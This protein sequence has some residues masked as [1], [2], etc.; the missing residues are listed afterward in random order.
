MLEP[1]DQTNPPHQLF[2]APSFK[3]E[4]RFSYGEKVR[5][6]RSRLSDIGGR[7]GGPVRRSPKKTT[8]PRTRRDGDGDGRRTDP[9]TGKD[10]IP[11][12]KQAPEPSTRQRVKRVAPETRELIASMLLDG[13]KYDAIMEAAKV[14]R[15]VIAQVA[16]DLGERK[17]P[18]RGESKRTL[19]QRDL[20]IE[21]LRD[22]KKYDE[23]VKTT[24]L[25]LSTI[26][27]IAKQAQVDVRDKRK[28]EQLYFV[29]SML[30]K[31]RTVAEIAAAGRMAESTVKRRIK[32]LQGDNRRKPGRPPKAQSSQP[33]NA[34]P[35][36]RQTKPRDAIRRKRRRRGSPPPLKTLA[37]KAARLAESLEHIDKLRANQSEDDMATMFGLAWADIRR[38]I[39]GLE[40]LD[41]LGLPF[42]EFSKIANTP[43]EELTQAESDK[44]IAAMAAIANV[45][46]NSA[47]NP[48]VIALRSGGA[49]S[50]MHSTFN[51]S[52]KQL[53]PS[54][55]DSGKPMIDGDGDGKCREHG[56]KWVPCP[57]GVPAG[58]LLGRIA[59]PIDHLDGID[60][61]PFRMYADEADDDAAYNLERSA[62][63]ES[64][65][66]WRECRAMRRHAYTIVSGRESAADPH[67][68]RSRPNFFGDPMRAG[69][70]DETQAYFQARYLLNQLAS[71]A[72]NGDNDMLHP[73]VPEPAV[74]R[75]LYRAVQLPE[76]A[77]P[78]WDAFA[79]NAI[80]DIP[81]MATANGHKV[82]SHDYLSRY[83]S[84]VLIEI[85]GP[86]VGLT[87]GAIDVLADEDNEEES[88]LRLRMAID[89]S[90]DSDETEF[91]A[92][93]FAAE[94]RQLLD[95]YEEAQQRNNIKQQR[96][97]LALLKIRLEELG[98]RDEYLFAGDKLPESDIRYWDRIEDYN[99]EGQREV[100]T[101]G[102]Y[103]VVDIADDPEGTYQKRIILD[104]VG[105][106]DPRIS[107]ALI[108][109]KREQ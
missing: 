35:T 8:V 97:I 47:Y 38:A 25:S 40:V 102:R 2:A 101:G 7:I 45:Y 49:K 92:D 1:P 74:D 17:K 12:D 79:S 3:V 11:V 26:E 37:A 15:N 68:R 75:K 82:G 53:G 60:L 105:V 10:N 61:D 51:N 52:A 19:E 80:V 55:G 18:M 39:K 30:A 95:D 16:K 43:L 54:I 42:G 14:S 23:I 88:L 41:N 103:R 32:E 100:I 70:V 34:L 28:K 64:W 85:R 69:D 93:P 99:S 57:P 56:D 50:L 106:F 65:Q 58:T 9:R 77:T 62:R 36:A 67:L 63:F 24:N 107:G 44:F 90:V 76:D 108:P 29:A 84:D 5:F 27:R 81:L 78:F 21:M 46:K 91:D 4:R 6:G 33:V 13:Q 73:G 94:I 96:K 86:N 71:L 87:S 72:Q 83:G 48:F 104:H 31:K 98:W 89:E 20:V 59:E 22:G 109:I 66:Q